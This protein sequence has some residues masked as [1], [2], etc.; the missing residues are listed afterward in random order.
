MYVNIFLIIIIK[1]KY[2]TI[3]R[4]INFQQTKLLSKCFKTITILKFLI[5]YIIHLFFCCCLFI[6]GSVLQCPRLNDWRDCL[7]RYYSLLYNFVCINGW[8]MEMGNRANKW[9][10][11]KVWNKPYMD[12]PETIDFGGRHTI[13]GAVP[14]HSSTWLILIPWFMPS[15]KPL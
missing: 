4:I 1:V 8:E 10:K 14:I 12:K 9:G 2:S 11:V 13:D 15:L 7:F 5:F 3:V 6:V